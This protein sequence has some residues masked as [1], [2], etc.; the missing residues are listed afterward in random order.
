[1]SHLEVF[2]FENHAVRINLDAENQPWFCFKDVC[3]AL[4]IVNVGVARNRM[5]SSGICKTDVSINNHIYKMLFIN[6]PNLYRA[7][8]QSVKPEAKRFQNWVFEEVLPAIR[9]TGSCGQPQAESKLTHYPELY[10]A[11]SRIEKL[12]GYDAET[13]SMHLFR[14]MRRILGKEYRKTGT[15]LGEISPKY[16]T[17]LMIWL[18]NVEK[19][20]LKMSQICANT[21]QEFIARFIN[22]HE[23]RMHINPDSL[24]HYYKMNVI[25]AKANE[26]DFLDHLRGF[27]RY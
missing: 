23:L 21:E 7:I 5:E 19:H 27:D 14:Q 20:A 2:K 3:D 26:Q 6:E 1:M 8:F 24:P 17:Y 4:T 22:P 11:V 10:L 12:F 18:E 15:D 13:A 25:Y 16:L 9:K